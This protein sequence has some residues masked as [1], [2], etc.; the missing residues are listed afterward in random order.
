VEKTLPGLVFLDY[1]MERTGH[2]EALITEADLPAG[3]IVEYFFK[4]G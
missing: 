2:C 1:L 3:L 4:R